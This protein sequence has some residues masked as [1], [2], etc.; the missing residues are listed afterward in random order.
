MM[1]YISRLSL[2]RKAL[3]E[4]YDIIFTERSIYTDKNV[5]AQMLYDSKQMSTTEYLIYNKWFNEFITDLPV[6][7]IIY[8]N[9]LGEVYFLT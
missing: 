1:A 6:D 2:L 8:L 4:E 5:F 3:K 7:K 9:T